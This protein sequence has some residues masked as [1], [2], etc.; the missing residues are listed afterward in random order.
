[1][2]WLGFVAGLGQLSWWMST[3][4][5]EKAQGLSAGDRNSG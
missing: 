3:P 5:D 1:M 4:I 2:S